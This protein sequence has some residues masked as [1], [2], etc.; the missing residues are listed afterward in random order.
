MRTFRLCFFFQQTKP[1][2]PGTSHTKLCCTPSRG[3]LRLKIRDPR[4]SLHTEKVWKSNIT[5]LLKHFIARGRIRDGS[6]GVDALR[7][8]EEPF[9]KA[10]EQMAHNT[11]WTQ[12][13]TLSGFLLEREARRRREEK[14]SKKTTINNSVVERMDEDD[15]VYTASTSKFHEKG[16]SF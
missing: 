1:N 14:T 7:Q 8:G 12:F 3:C 10:F 9:L 5:F 6:L 16:L 13:Q 11:T 15:E 2:H 4:N